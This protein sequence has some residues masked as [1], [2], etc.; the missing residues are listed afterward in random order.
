[1]N[2]ILHF[3]LGSFHRA[4]QAV[5]LNQLHKL[6]D[7]SWVLAG[8]NIRADM[9]DTIAALQASGGAYTLE[10]ISPQGE[11][12]VERITA[13]KQVIAYTPDLAGLIACGADELFV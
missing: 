8:G 6:G 13:I 3:G 2:R 5:Y 10:T 4:H 7:T 9:A 11:H 1:M 12:V